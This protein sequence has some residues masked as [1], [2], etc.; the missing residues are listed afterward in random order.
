MYIFAGIEPNPQSIYGKQNK[1][2]FQGVYGLYIWFILY[3]KIGF[4]TWQP[5]GVL[6]DCT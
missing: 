3:S 6:L 1:V 5:I 2:A 4:Y